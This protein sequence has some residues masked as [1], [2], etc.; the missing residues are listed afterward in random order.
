MTAPDLA[1]P[2]NETEQ[3]YLPGIVSNPATG[4][5]KDLIES[6]RARGAE[7]SKIWD[8]FAFQ[9]SFTVHMARFTEGALRTPTSI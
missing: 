7:Y 2:G 8:L 6:A 3:L 1:F 5:Y 9:E 4:L